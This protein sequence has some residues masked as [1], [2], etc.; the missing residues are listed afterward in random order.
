MKKRN[1]LKKYLYSLRA[2][3]IVFLSWMISSILVLA[4]SVFLH[5][6]WKE[7]NRFTF[8]QAQLFVGILTI[9]FGSVL[10]YVFTTRASH[11]TK[12][13]T[14]CMKKVAEGDFS[15]RMEKLDNESEL[16]SVIDSFN[17]MVSDLNSVS[18]L[19]QDFTSTFSHEFKTPITSIRGYAE[20]LAQADNVT[21]EQKEYLK[22]IIDESKHLSTLAER[23]LL[24]SKLDSQNIITDKTLF[25][26]NDQIEQCILLFDSQMTQK[27]IELDYNPTS[28]N[29]RANYDLLKEVWTNL[30]SN[31]VKFSNEN[32]KIS[33]KIEKTLDKAMVTITDNGIGMDEETLSKVKEKFYQGNTDRKKSGLGLGLSIVE[34][35]IEISNGTLE[36]SSKLNEGTKVL[37]TLP[38]E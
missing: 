20:I 38:I 29:V 35:I 16:A 8:F 2:T 24:L 27:A 17:K 31:A 3:A 33:V 19:R 22:V 5:S 37:V 25:S 36:I 7:F 34:K 30:L 4:L 26:L 32:G 28:V 23:T 14:K 10:T 12:S 9:I 6:A 15:V 11:M 18:I 1:R 21:A 13:F